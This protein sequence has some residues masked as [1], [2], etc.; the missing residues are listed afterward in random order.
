VIVNRYT[1]EKGDLFAKFFLI[2]SSENNRQ[3]RTTD[4]ANERYARTAI[5]TPFTLMLSK[6]DSKYLDY[7]PFLPDPD[8]PV[9][10]QIDFAYK[11]AIGQIVDVNRESGRYKAAYGGPDGVVDNPWFATVKI[12]DP[13]AKEEFQKPDSKLIPRAVSPGLIHLAGPDD[14][15]TEYHIVHLAAVPSGA[16]GPRAIKWASCNG[17][18]LSCIPRLKAASSYKERTNHCPLECLSSLAQKSG[19]SPNIMSAVNNTV[20]PGPQ[21]FGSGTVETSQPPTQSQQGQVPITKPTIRIRRYKAE[22]QQEENP[23]GNG[24]QTPEGNNG[25]GEQQQQEG[26]QQAPISDPN[27]DQAFRSSRYYQEMQNMK[28]ELQARTQQWDYKE[29]RYQ[30]EKVI[31]PQLFTDNKGRF[32][33]KDWEAEIERAI[34]ENVPMPFLQDYYQTKLLALQVPEIQQKRASAKGASSQNYDDED[35]ER[36]MKLIELGKLIRGVF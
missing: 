14:A 17:D 35:N 16:Y 36:R 34:K 31:P 10:D 3:W 28:K 26:E 18:A 30:L 8:A 12:T 32:R 27:A 20:T 11:Y 4:A 24:Q 21:S 7:H 9:K 13:M 33:Q 6:E 29:K 22:G 23:N 25:N 1:D 15:I 5:G 2:D 19:S